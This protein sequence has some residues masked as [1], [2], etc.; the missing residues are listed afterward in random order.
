MYFNKWFS[1][2]TFKSFKFSHKSIKI[3]QKYSIP[4][5][6]F[7]FPYFVLYKSKKLFGNSCPN[8]FKVLLILNFNYEAIIV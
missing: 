6:V 5:N 4:I 8:S 1:F 3:T 2:Y 7:L